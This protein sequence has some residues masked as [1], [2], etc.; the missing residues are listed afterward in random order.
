MSLKKFIEYFNKITILLYLFA[1][2][3]ISKVSNA[4]NDHFL[5]NARIGESEQVLL[6]LLAEESTVYLPDV[7]LVFKWQRLAKV[8]TSTETDSSLA[9]QM[10]AE[11][12]Q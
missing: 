2:N 10:L 6:E 7:I 9:Q 5:I 3:I 12:F 8:L 4:F 11:L 1:S